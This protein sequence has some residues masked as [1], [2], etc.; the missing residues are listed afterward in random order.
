MGILPELET[1]NVE[2]WPNCWRSNASAATARAKVLFGSKSVEDPLPSPSGEKPQPRKFNQEHSNIFR[3]VPS[4]FL[5]RAESMPPKDAQPTVSAFAQWVYSLYG[6]SEGN[7]EDRERGTNAEKDIFERRLSAAKCNDSEYLEKARS[8]WSLVHCGLQSENPGKLYFELPKLKLNGKSM[9]ASPDLIYK[10]AHT[11]EIIIVE[12]KYSRME[13]PRNLW[14][15]IWAQL[16]CYAQIEVAASAND[17]AVVGEVWGE[18]WSRGYGRGINRV[19]GQKLIC[20]RASVRRDPR[21]RAYDRFFREL[22]HIY[23]G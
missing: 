5:R 7:E 23:C 22:F 1:E 4:E 18:M 20:L 11:S 3:L 19:E 14:P 12:I 8:P 9:K 15:N 13:I 21:A 10:N 6:H 16:W 2:F 17:V